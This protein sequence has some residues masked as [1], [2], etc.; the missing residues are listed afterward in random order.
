[1][2]VQHLGHY[3]T[4]YGDIPTTESLHLQTIEKVNP[5][6]AVALVSGLEASIEVLKAIKAP[7]GEH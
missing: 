6:M 3:G 7:E 2:Q 5:E 4:R 1:M